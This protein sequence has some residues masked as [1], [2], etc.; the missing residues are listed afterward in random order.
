MFVTIDSAAG[1]I[2]AAPSPWTARLAIRNPSLVASA[3]ASDAAVNTPSATHQD[4][5][6]AE[7]ISGAATQ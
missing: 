6:A 3:Q 7:Q 5:A 1:S 4:A 2:T